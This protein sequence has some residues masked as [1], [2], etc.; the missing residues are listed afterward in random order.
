LPSQ[1]NTFLSEALLHC[2]HRAMLY[3]LMERLRRIFNRMVVRGD[4]LIPP[5]PPCNPELAPPN[6][7]GTIR[8]TPAQLQTMREEMQRHSLMQGA[9]SAP[10]FSTMGGALMALQMYVSTMSV[11]N[12]T[13]SHRN[14][15]TK[16]KINFSTSTDYNEHT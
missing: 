1:L 10:P 11:D 9:G 6:L 13:F 8:L 14:H 4:T 5:C 15:H 7:N 16:C 3:N 12:P 2:F